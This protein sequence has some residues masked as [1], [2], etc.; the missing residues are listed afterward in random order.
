MHHFSHIVL[1][2]IHRPLRPE[3]SA[4]RHALRVA[5]YSSLSDGDRQ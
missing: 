2:Y 4:L 5:H 1:W 3:D